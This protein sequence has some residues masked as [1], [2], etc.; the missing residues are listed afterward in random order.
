MRRISFFICLL[1]LFCQYTLAQHQHPHYLDGHLYVKILDKENR[2][3]YSVEELERF[4][5]PLQWVQLVQEYE[6]QSIEPAFPALHSIKLDRTYEIRFDRTDKTQ[7]F[8]RDLAG[9]GYL[10]YAERVPIA[11]KTLTPDDPFLSNQWFLNT[12]Q[13]LQAHN[14]HTGGNSVV[15]IVDDA[16]RITHEDLAPNLWTNPGE[17]PNDNIDNDGNGYI[18]DIHGWDPADQ[19]NDPNPPSTATNSSFTH[20]THCAGRI[21]VIVLIGR[22]PTVD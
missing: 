11:R 21:G 19:D 12:I 14:I 15:A 16:V 6:V 7:A 18:D 8:L 2:R 5:K 4:Q 22:V 20:G 10:E 3:L 1:S 13:A 17:I 9:I